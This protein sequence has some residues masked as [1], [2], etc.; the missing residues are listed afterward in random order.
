MPNNYFTLA[1]L[2]NEIREDLDGSR[3]LAC[4]TRVERTLEIAIEKREGDRRDLVVSCKPR[5]NYLFLDNLPKKHLSGANVLAEAV[6]AIINSVCVIENERTV[7][8]KLSIGKSL[9]MNLFGSHANVLLADEKNKVVGAFL[10]RKSINPADLESSLAKHGFPGNAE[11]FVINFKAAAGSPQ[12]R[13]SKVVPPFSGRLAKEVFYR[14]GSEDAA[15][16]AVNRELS[17]SDDQLVVLF[18]K[19]SD[20]RRELV[21][22]NPRIYFQKDAPLSLSLIEMKHLGSL[23]TAVYKS[24][25][26]CVGAFV[27]DTERHSSQVELKNALLDRLMRRKEDLQSTILKIEKDISEN[28]E[29]RYREYGELLMLH[30]NEIERGASFFQKHDDNGSLIVPLDSKLTPVRN[31]QQY[32]EK[33]KKAR[34]SCRLAIA[35]KEELGRSLDKVDSELQEVERETDCRLLISIGKKEKAKDEAQTPFRQ[36]EIKGYHIY[37][38]KD[39]KSNEELTFGFAKPNDVFLH[40]RGVSGSHV[41]IRNSS[42]EI[43]EKPILE[44]AASIA[45]HY[46]KARSSSIV[47]VAYTMRKFVKKAKR[48]PGAVLIDREEVIFV[49]PEIPSSIRQR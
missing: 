48:K 31:A 23:T 44:Y 49:K 32:F 18:E 16:N 20:M 24:V 10:K 1:A 11:E 17:L 26:S 8:L 38:G 27:A 45:A 34:E 36:F 5:M 2:I 19:I 41:I 30:L 22:P 29:K 6:G 21:E 9:F 35:R 47:P 43:P 37:V 25:N 40:A 46:S 13:L 33:A 12:Q 3:I 39:A 15:E 7:V 42:R 4:F 14:L 28:R